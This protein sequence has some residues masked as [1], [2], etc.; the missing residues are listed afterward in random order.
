MVGWEEDL[1]TI[2][3]REEQRA[4]TREVLRGFLL[5]C[6][7]QMHRTRHLNT[8]RARAC[9]WTDA[10]FHPKNTQVRGTMI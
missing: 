6:H 3:K 7:L 1:L 10:Q 4:R 8:T 5:E 9:T 2:N